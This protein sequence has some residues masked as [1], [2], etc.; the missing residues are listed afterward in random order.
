MGS[1]GG[2][3]PTEKPM[4]TP[5]EAVGT[6]A[7][8]ANISSASSS[9]RTMYLV[10]MM[11]PFNLLKK[12]KLLR[13]RERVE[14]IPTA[15]GLNTVGWRKSLTLGMTEMEAVAWVF[16]QRKGDCPRDSYC[17]QFYS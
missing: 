7:G 1:A 16:A 4:P 14:A 11:S 3:I 15:R 12:A 9:K 17:R 2:A 13:L 10:L 5:A 6:V 8:M